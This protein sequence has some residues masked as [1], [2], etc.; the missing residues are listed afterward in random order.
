[1]GA[2]PS[3]PA[4]GNR[5]DG[6]AGNQF[7]GAP[8]SVFGAPAPVFGSVPPPAYEAVSLARKP[9][10]GWLSY[11]SGVRGVIVTVVLLLVA[12]SIGYNRFTFVQ[13]LLKGDLKAPSSLAGMPRLTGPEA[14]QA[15]RQGLE[16]MKQAGNMGKPLVA[17]YTDG[18]GYYVLVAAR[19]KADIAREFSDVGRDMSQV[20]TVGE[21]SCA[22]VE[23]E[24]A[25]LR[26]SRTLTVWVI[27][28][29]GDA[30]VAGA[31]NEAW[32]SL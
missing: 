17:V 14:D 15:E 24:T 12:V 23:A 19:G 7:G 29:A 4:A 5:F 18:V 10:A 2:P 22:T 20:R 31:I 26:T 21:S 9:S 13:N 32:P 25:C 28:S 3:S 8:A 11:P 27:G 1:V 30:Q 16:A 6:A